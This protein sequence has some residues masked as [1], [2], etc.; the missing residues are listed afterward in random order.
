MLISS[1]L[2]AGE[3]PE[4]LL[5]GYLELVSTS[6]APKGPQPELIPDPDHSSIGPHMAYAVQ[7][8][9]FSA[10]VPVGWVVLLR[11]ERAEALAARAKK[12]SPEAPREPEESARVA[13]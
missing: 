7:W 13:V 12:N 3:M 10:M 4:R 11:R 5:G 2:L 6:P 1:T 9:L 8:W